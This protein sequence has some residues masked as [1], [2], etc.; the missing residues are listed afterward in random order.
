M[1]KIFIIIIITISLYRHKNRTFDANVA[2]SLSS[3]IPRQIRVKFDLCIKTMINV[4]IRCPSLYDYIELVPWFF[5]R[6]LVS[7][8]GNGVVYNIPNL[9]WN[10]PHHFHIIR[11]SGPMNW[12]H[13]FYSFCK[14][15][16]E[17]HAF[18]Y[19]NKW[20]FSPIFMVVGKVN[21]KFTY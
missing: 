10:I 11:G 1:E 13:R 21:S 15:R 8:L 18:V 16:V 3:H 19:V 4:T 9:C 2:N 17:T 20:T 14:E 5:T 7:Y 12:W 6:S